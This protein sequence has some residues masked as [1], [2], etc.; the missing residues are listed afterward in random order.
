MSRPFFSIITVVYNAEAGFEKTAQSLQDQDFRDFEWIV[1]DGGSTDKTLDIARTYIDP[2]RDILVSEPDDGVYDAMNKGLR[3]ARGQVVQF[4]NANDWF[5]SDRVLSKIFAV[6]E[7]GV[8]A[9]YGDTILSLADGRQIARPAIDP[10]ANL[11]RRMA[12][13]HQALFVKRETHLLYPFD[14]KF[15]VSADKA[16][17]SKMYV[18]GVKMVPAKVITNVN[19]IEP[20]AVSIAGKVRSAAEDYRISI[21]I[22]RRPRTEAVYYYLRKR[23]VIFG[24]DLLERLPKPVFDRLPE[25]IRRRVY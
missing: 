5:A 7:E 25:G 9:V 20:E 10:G 18:A 24:V 15:S 4:L 13:S 1:V 19:S 12:F 2:K 14:L 11:R 8:E 22:L 21:D 17:I 3:L 6:F 23:L 16:A